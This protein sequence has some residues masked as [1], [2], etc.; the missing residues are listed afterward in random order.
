MT[1]AIFAITLIRLN[2]KVLIVLSLINF[3]SILNNFLK[4]AKNKRVNNNPRIKNAIAAKKF[5]IYGCCSVEPNQNSH[6]LAME[7][8]KEFHMSLRKVDQFESDKIILK[9]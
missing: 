7:F 8:F 9:L 3:L 2:K 5:T 4:I 1:I 6:K